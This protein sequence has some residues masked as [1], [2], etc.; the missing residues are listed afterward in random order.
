MSDLQK[1][2]RA[3]MLE[4]IKAL[5]ASNEKLVAAAQYALLFAD[6]DGSWTM[7]GTYGDVRPKWVTR[8]ISALTSTE[9][10]TP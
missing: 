3:N 5:R 4:E 8:L 7:N 1:E 9:G 2:L 10:N 6:P